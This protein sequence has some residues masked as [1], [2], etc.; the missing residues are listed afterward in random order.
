MLLFKL[1]L[2]THV[3]IFIQYLICKTK[4]YKITILESQPSLGASYARTLLQ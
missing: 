2:C 1:T 3:S 4:I